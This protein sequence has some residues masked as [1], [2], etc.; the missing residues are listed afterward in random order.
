MAG[1]FHAPGR[2]SAV[3]D[4]PAAAHSS[5]TDGPACLEIHLGHRRG[6]LRVRNQDGGVSMA[7]G[8]PHRTLLT[9][10]MTRQWSVALRAC[11]PAPDAGA[12]SRPRD[13]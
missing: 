2:P 12:H 1:N 7:V 6:I 5:M 9:F 10:T 13:P 3:T 11:L 4:T 8:S